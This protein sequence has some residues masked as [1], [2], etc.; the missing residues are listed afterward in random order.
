MDNI[1]NIYRD[2]ENIIHGV[3]QRKKLGLSHYN[4]LT[5]PKFLKLP[6]IYLFAE[7]TH[8][9]SCPWS[10]C[11]SQRENNGELTNVLMAIEM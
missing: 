3:A 8:L 7:G 10:K 6:H 9:Q 11:N 1:N 5:L 2:L 4:L